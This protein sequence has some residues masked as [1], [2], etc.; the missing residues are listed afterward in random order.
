MYVT[1]VQV[2]L[3]RALLAQ[4]RHNE[5]LAF[6]NDAERSFVRDTAVPV[7]TRCVVAEVQH[8]RGKLNQA[9]EAG[10]EAVRL[11]R[12]TDSPDLQGDAERILGKISIAHDREL[13]ER[14]VDQA[15]ILFTKKENL[16]SAAET[17]LLLK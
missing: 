14:H 8:H 9:I 1:N 4:G 2:G 5:A 12:R 3:A 17:R 15:L 7:H 11:A 6:A 16:V 10:H 13:G